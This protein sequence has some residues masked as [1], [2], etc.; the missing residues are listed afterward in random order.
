MLDLM[1]PSK[2][3]VVNRLF[4]TYLY[5]TLALFSGQCGYVKN[6]L[7]SLLANWDTNTRMSLWEWVGAYRFR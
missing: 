3:L 5:K 1:H 2:M 4:F 6:I 7:A